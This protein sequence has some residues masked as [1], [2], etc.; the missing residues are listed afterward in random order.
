MLF[1][2]GGYRPIFLGDEC[3]NARDLPANGAKLARLLELP[4]L[5]LEPQV[6]NFFAQFP[7]PGTEVVQAQFT[8]FFAFHG[9]GVVSGEKLRPDRKLI[10]R[11]P[12]RLPGHSFGYT[13]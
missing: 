10:G 12:E 4:T 8:N 6:K 11:K 13:V 2:G 3:L 1:G 5:L 7:F 9:S